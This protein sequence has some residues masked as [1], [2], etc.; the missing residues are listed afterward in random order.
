[1]AIIYIFVK[2]YEIFFTRNKTMFKR[3]LK[4]CIYRNSKNHTH[5]Q[6]YAYNQLLNIFA[7]LKLMA[8][9]ECV[10]P[11]VSGHCKKTRQQ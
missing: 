10:Y 7:H 1:M 4:V 11:I 5:N 9:Q 3:S 8:I 2:G 6:I